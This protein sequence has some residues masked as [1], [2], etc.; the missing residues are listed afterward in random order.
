MLMARRLA[1]EEGLLVG[2]STGVNVVAAAEVAR[3]LDDPD[4]LV[5]TILC[6]T[7][8]R[9]LSKVFS[10]EWLRENQLLDDERRTVQR[11]LA[12]KE[13]GAPTLVHVAPSG[14]VRQALNLMS[15]YNVSQLPVIDGTEG[16][17]AVSEQSLMANALEDPHMLDRPVGE[18]MD[19]P[20]PVV[21]AD[22]P[23]E[24]LGALLSRETPAALVRRDGKLAGI[25]TRYDLLHQLAGLR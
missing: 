15:T 1:R 25:V 4:A 24:R 21:D 11:I 2:G 22:Y 3:R 7:G 18:V 19:A 20:F 8:E 17:G 14:T 13:N 5:V 16:V 12:A 23:V 9:Y 6:D 10:D